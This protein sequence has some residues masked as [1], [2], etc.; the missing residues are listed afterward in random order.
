MY[1]SK[2]LQERMCTN[3]EIKNLVYTGKDF[4]DRVCTRKKSNIECTL[5]KGS[6]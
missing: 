2:V 6:N 4:K 1:M 3:E 5:V